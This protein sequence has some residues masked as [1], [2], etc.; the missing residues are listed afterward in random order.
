MYFDLTVFS[1]VTKKVK[2]PLVYDRARNVAFGVA[3]LFPGGGRPVN[4]DP[5]VA[6]CC[7]ALWGIDWC[8]GEVAM[9]FWG[10]GG[11]VRVFF[12]LWMGLVSFYAGS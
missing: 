1:V 5:E 11:K 12:R 6:E 7:A 4:F 10:C 3:G 2:R 9:F 8:E